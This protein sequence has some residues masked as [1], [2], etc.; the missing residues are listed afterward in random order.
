MVIPALVAVTLVTFLIT[1]QV[2][3]DPLT[4]VLGQRAMNNPEIV[5]NCRAK[6]EGC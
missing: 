3:D 6:V 4:A 1:K 2:P 5:A